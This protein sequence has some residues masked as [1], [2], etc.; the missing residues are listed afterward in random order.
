MMILTLHRSETSKTERPN[1]AA[2]PTPT[3]R[4]SRVETARPAATVFALWWPRNNPTCTNQ[5]AYLQIHSFTDLWLLRCKIITTYH[6]N[7]LHL[8]I[9][10]LTKKARKD[11]SS[12]IPKKKKKRKRQ[13]QEY[14]MARLSLFFVI[15][16]RFIK[17][18]K[19]I[20]KRSPMYLC[21]W[22]S[23]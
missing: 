23:R 11:Q 22:F 8:N 18:F 14:L 16:L 13:I 10:E 9:I 6:G 19:F 17:Y 3:T 21:E 12:T 20:F 4:R 15:V 2:P 7:C 1:R 5:L